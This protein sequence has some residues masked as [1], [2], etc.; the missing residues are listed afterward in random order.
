MNLHGTSVPQVIVIE[1]L[2][3]V[4]KSTVVKALVEITGGSDVTEVINGSMGEG[5]RVVMASDSVNA[6]LHYW[7]AGNY[8]AGEYAAECVAA[9]RTAVIDSYFFRTIACHKVL[10]ARFDWK[11]VLFAATR[12]DRAVLL[13]VSEEVRATRLLERGGTAST[14][15]WHAELD[16]RWMEVA[17]SA[18]R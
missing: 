12:P 17:V 10:G 11:T 16:S 8:L 4:G 7:L 2:D 6:R 18:V 13:T 9:K 5:R 1:G 15:E 14:P 3:G